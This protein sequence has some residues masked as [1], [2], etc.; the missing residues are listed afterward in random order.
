MVSIFNKIDFDL[1]EEL[2]YLCGDE[3]SREEY[4]SHEARH[5][6]MTVRFHSDGEDAGKG[7]RAAI[8]V[9]AKQVECGPV[10]LDGEPK[11]DFFKYLI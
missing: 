2:T 3:G 5:N 1:D 9:G 6:Q 10:T 7:F 11:N 8:S 4:R